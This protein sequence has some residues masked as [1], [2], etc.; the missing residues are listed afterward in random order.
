MTT[1][2]M[3]VVLLLLCSSASLAQNP[4]RNAAE[5]VEVRYNHS[6][7]VVHYVLRVGPGD[8][9]GFDVEMHIRNAPDTFQL[10][11]M[12]HPEYDD[13]YWRFVSGLRLASPR[14][15]PTVTRV[16][17]ALWRV[18]AA[19]GESIVRYRV[20]PPLIA[21]AT[22]SAWRAFIC[23]TGGLVGG[24]HSFM[25]IVGS[26]LAPAHV[27]LELPD[28]WDIATGLEPTS[29]PRIYFAPTAVVLLDSPILI[30]GLRNWRFTVDGT[31]HRVAY[32][33]LP[34]ATPFDTATFVSSLERVAR[35]AIALFGRAPYRDFTFLMVDG[36]LGGLEHANSVNIGAPSATLARDAG[37][38]TAETAHEYFHAWNEVRIRPVEY[39]G[40]D[41][42][43]AP[44]STG[45]WWYEGVT[46]LY[47]DLLMRRAG[48]RT[49]DSTRAGRLG[50]TIARY[51]GSSGNT[52]LS[53][54]RASLLANTTNMMD[55]GDD[56]ASVHVQGELVGDVLDLIVRD[57]TNGRRSLD[58]VI[59]LMM[60]RYSGVTGYTSAG[61]EGAVDAVCG[62]RT[63]DF[64]AQFV[65]TA[66]PIPFNRYLA[67][68]GLRSR[69]V[70]TPA[71]H[72]DGTPT[73]D[74]AVFAWLPAGASHPRLRVFDRTS[75]W[76]KA[77]LHT[78]DSVMTINGATITDVPGFRSAVLGLTVG[79]SVRIEVARGARR[80]RA[81]FVLPRLMEPV[82]TIEETPGATA[83]Q[84][85]LRDAWMR[86][87]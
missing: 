75:A 70:S 69:I 76:A 63:H 11:M 57:A 64:F 32:W 59:R 82:V 17:S 73:P 21:S 25:Y 12:A 68:V 13:R 77:G 81:A 79:D 31:P 2:R 23:A 40:I 9:T 38:V 3:A 37:A 60:E 8:T 30:G 35:E 22:R 51:L 39:H 41:Y 27:K 47:A 87:R 50:A 78:G 53:P 56:N 58:D 33:P 46:M 6:Q 86:A 18:A 71:T 43:P 65:R 7:P 20:Q 54:E 26:E 85:A 5:A 14:G 45:V 29:D 84:R 62:C 34:T 1:C 19:G 24:P 28:G 36:A 83:K 48:L 74:L 44:V 52:L 42:R 72:A 4:F 61:I 49:E 67:L 55:Y 16:D 66:H 80:Y 10:A 15:E